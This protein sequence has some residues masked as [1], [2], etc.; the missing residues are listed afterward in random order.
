M[1]FNQTHILMGNVQIRYY[2]IIIVTALLVGAYVASLL[3]KRTGRD[4]DHI[5]GGLTWAIIPGIIGARLWFVFFPPIS[6]TAG[7]SVV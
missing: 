6:L 3:A 1:E 2:G 5:W 4:P 7:K